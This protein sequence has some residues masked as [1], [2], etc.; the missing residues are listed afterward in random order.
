MQNARSECAIP[1]LGHLHCLNSDSEPRCVIDQSFIHV[2]LSVSFT[3]V[4]IIFMRVD[5]QETLKYADDINLY[6]WQCVALYFGWEN[7]VIRS[8]CALGC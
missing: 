8:V 3:S 2:S 6:G 7:P 5:A 4:V 1:D